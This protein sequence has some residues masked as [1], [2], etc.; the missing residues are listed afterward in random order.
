MI[1]SASPQLSTFIIGSYNIEKA[2]AML[3]IYTKFSNQNKGMAGL[4]RNISLNA[5]ASKV[6]MSSKND[7]SYY[8]EELRML[9][10]LAVGEKD[11]Q[12]FLTRIDGDVEHN[13]FIS[14]VRRIK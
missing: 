7:A 8:E 6:P 4:L 14:S 12:V 5:L 3:R 9:P 10:P 2:D 11:S 1:K 13:N